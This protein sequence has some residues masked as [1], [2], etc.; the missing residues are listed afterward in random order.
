MSSAAPGEAL[1]TGCQVA[2]LPAGHQTPPVPGKC[3]VSTGVQKNCSDIQED[4]IWGRFSPSRQ[5]ACL[6]HGEDRDSRQG[7]SDVAH[8]VARLGSASCERGG[9]R[10]QKP[11]GAWFRKIVLLDSMCLRRKSLHVHWRADKQC[12]NC[13]HHLPRACAVRVR[14]PKQVRRQHARAAPY[15]QHLALQ[16]ANVVILRESKI[17]LVPW[18][19]LAAQLLACC[20][21]VAAGCRRLPGQHAMGKTMSMRA[22][23]PH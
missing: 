22:A 18:T 15:T 8:V 9:R 7:G 19:G 16:A 21:L 5:A 11:P 10:L 3:N 17:G 6:R 4:H 12:P 13:E 23:P 2:A 20:K 14:T 1:Y